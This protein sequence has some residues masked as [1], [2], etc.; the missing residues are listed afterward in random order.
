[1][2]HSK[3]PVCHVAPLIEGPG[4]VGRPLLARPGTWSNQPSNYTYFFQRGR[5][6]LGTTADHYTPREADCGHTI[7]VV[8]RAS[9]AHGYALASAA[10]GITIV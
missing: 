1:M 9:N 4:S 10:N 5:V 7:T 2:D 6:K 8:V 3:I